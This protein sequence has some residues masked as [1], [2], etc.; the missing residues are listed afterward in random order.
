MR[1]SNGTLTGAGSAAESGA[2]NPTAATAELA[3]YTEAVQLAKKLELII[4]SDIAYAEIYYDN[5]PPPSVL[6]V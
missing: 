2:D 6:Q 4:L 1:I 3:F 5:N